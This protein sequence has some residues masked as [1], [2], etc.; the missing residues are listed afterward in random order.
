MTLTDFSLIA[1]VLGV[2]V[3]GPIMLLV[4]NIKGLRIENHA[5][6]DDMKTEIEKLDHR[7]S[8]IEQHKVSH[9]DWV[10]VTVSHQNRQ[11]KISQ[12]IAELNGKVE[13]SFGIAA[14]I[15]RV[16]AALERKMGP[17]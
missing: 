10:R 6:R 4:S 15:T 17:I 7:V 1:G 11:E 9:A 2:V 14:G 5:F 12:Q 8:L 13:A 3:G 16:A